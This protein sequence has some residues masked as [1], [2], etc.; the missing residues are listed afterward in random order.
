MACGSL[1]IVADTGGLREVVPGDGT[2]GLRF[3]SHDS[4]ALGEVL[5]Q[6]L[7]DD[8]ARAKLVSEAREHVLGFDWAA[9]ACRTREVYLE[10]VAAGASFAVDP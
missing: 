2:V 1:C 7:T 5:A 4:A 8:L 3:R 6:I 10:L 9:V